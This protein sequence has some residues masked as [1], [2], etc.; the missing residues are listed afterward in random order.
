MRYQSNAATTGGVVRVRLLA[1]SRISPPFAHTIGM[2]HIAEIGLR[3]V[4]SAT[5]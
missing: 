2:V 4:R 3:S 5:P 1:A